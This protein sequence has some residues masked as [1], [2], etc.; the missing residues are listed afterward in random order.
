MTVVAMDFCCESLPRSDI[1]S[2]MRGYPICAGVVE[3]LLDIPRDNHGIP[4][5]PGRTIMLKYQLGYQ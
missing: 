3:K 1:L 4:G 2:L 5:C